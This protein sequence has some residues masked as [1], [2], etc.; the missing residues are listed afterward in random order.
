MSHLNS[1][2]QPEVLSVVNGNRKSNTY[3]LLV[4]E[5]TCNIYIT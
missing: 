4:E 3:L 2:I 5:D 1:I